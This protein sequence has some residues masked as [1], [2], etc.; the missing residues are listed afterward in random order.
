LGK[1]SQAD[2][3]FMPM[4]LDNGPKSIAELKF[5]YNMPFVFRN[6]KQSYIKAVD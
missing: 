5:Q 1:I 6:L 2:A 3:K 4:N